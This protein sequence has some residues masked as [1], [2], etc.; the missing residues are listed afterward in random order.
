[1]F[2]AGLVYGLFELVQS[3]SFIYVHEYI[4]SSLP[5]LRKGYFVPME[6]GEDSSATFGQEIRPGLVPPF[7]AATPV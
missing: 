3:I 7:F 5:F 1:M 2:E 6:A 4:L